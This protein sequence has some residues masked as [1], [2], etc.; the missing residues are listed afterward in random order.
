MAGRV[1][2]SSSPVTLT[3]AEIRRRFTEE[4]ILLDR[5]IR[6]LF[7]A[8]RSGSV[9]PAQA[10]YYVDRLV[11]LTGQ[12][13]DRLLLA[14]ID[15][16][17]ELL[18]SITLFGNYLEVDTPPVVD[19]D[20]RIRRVQP[21][22]VRVPVDMDQDVYFEHPV[23]LALK[24]RYAISQIETIEN[25]LVFWFLRH[26][27]SDFD[28][29]L[30]MQGNIITPWN[31]DFR[32]IDIDLFR[33]YEEAGRSMRNALIKADELG[34]FSQTLPEKSPLILDDYAFMLKEEM[35]KKPSDEESR[36]NWI[37][38]RAG[39][40]KSLE[41]FLFGSAESVLVRGYNEVIDEISSNEHGLA[42]L[43]S[44]RD[45][46]GKSFTSMRYEYEIFSAL[47]SKLQEELAMSF[48]IMG[49]GKNAEYPALLA[50]V[51]ITASHIIPFYDPYIFLWSLAAAFL[52]LFIIFLMR[53]V[54]LL[55]FG[56]CLSLIAA[57]VSG[58]L[59]I[60][61][62]IWLD[63]LIVL[64][65]SLSG[66]LLIF[67]CKCVIT[68]HREQKFTAAYGTSV[69]ENVL[70]NLIRF[71]KPEPNDIIVTSSS[72]IAIKDINLLK[73]EDNEKPQDAGNYKKQFVLS[74]KNVIYQAGGI[75]AGFEGDTILACFGSPLENSRTSQAD[76]VYRACTLVKDLLNDEK[77]TW[78]FGIDSG[79]CTFSWLP[80]TGYSV[81]GRPAV[82]ARILSS[83]TVRHK[84]RALVTECVHKKM[85]MNTK[86]IDSLYDDKESIYEFSQ[87]FKF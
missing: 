76:P 24:N 74:V 54:V 28:I 70:K 1:S 52:V 80:E 78:R 42:V 33:E 63:P 34:A 14:L 17:E 6:N 7:D 60:F 65:A 2:S 35:L 81:N 59:F 21:M 79:E 23:Y 71:G 48:C 53:P 8:I 86:K 44:M 22:A 50:N 82:R 5:N 66:T 30:D 84:S 37:T 16:D 29:P 58:C 46:L 45:E 43:A 85:N 11:E 73:R 9:S 32:R 31:C 61:H 39:Y 4:N 87:V 10:P 56:F 51:L 20:G 13:R 36:Y 49:Y 83:K 75:I 40:L 77:N 64:S 62:S 25:N 15:R 12:G 68:K 27:K 3:E 41:E 55:I 69:S 67:Y 19:P 18:S 72:V 47:H 38:A 57:S 26:D